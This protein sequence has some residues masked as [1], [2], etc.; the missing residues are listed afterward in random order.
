MSHKVVERPQLSCTSQHKC[1]IKHIYCFSYVNIY[2]CRRLYCYKYINF[3]W[4]RITYLYKLICIYFILSHTCVYIYFVL[5]GITFL[6]S[7]K[8]IILEY[9][10][11][12]FILFWEGVF[13]YLCKKEKLIFWPKPLFLV[14]LVLHMNRLQCNSYS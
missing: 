3:C 4:R 9:F 7:I 13:F 8:T 14:G 6:V 5:W 12:F 1:Y 2:I 10:D 11:F